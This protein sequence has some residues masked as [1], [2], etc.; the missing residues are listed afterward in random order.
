MMFDF[1]YQYFFETVELNRRQILVEM[2]K[3]KPPV[4]TEIYNILARIY[5]NN[6]SIFFVSY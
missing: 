3:I 6:V 1:Y 2:L 4:V 5:I